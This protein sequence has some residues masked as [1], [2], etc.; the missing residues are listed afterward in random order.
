MLIL[1]KN[2]KFVDLEW[3]SV[4]FFGGCQGVTFI[5]NVTTPYTVIETACQF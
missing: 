2:T 1:I 5:L 3:L 4:L